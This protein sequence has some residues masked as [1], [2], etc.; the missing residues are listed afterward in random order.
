[1]SGAKPA[2]WARKLQA[3]LAHGQQA[4]LGR[5]RWDADAL[6]DLVRDYV[7]ETLAAGDAVPAIDETPLLRAHP[8]SSDSR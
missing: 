5:G 3:I 4:V 2:G 8:G 7:V 6:Q 1:M